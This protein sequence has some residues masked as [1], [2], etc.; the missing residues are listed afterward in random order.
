MRDE[1]I[2]GIYKSKESS[3]YYFLLQ[4]EK[5]Q[6]TYWRKFIEEFGRYINK[7]NEEREEEQKS[8]IKVKEIIESEVF[9]YLL[10]NDKYRKKVDI[11][12]SGDKLEIG[13]SNA[14][15]LKMYQDISVL[16]DN[17]RK[18]YEKFITR[19]EAKMRTD[20]IQFDA[21]SQIV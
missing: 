16:C 21:D 3:S 5:I 8:F 13:R 9:Q 15:L 11:I 18:E 10:E 1:L 20:L 19:A 4:S 17:Y 2:S 6:E 12:F 14:K 7:N